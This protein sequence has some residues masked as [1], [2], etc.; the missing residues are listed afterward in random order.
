M[1]ISEINYEKW[2]KVL[3]RI[4]VI[5]ASVIFFVE[6]VDNLVLYITRSQGYGPDTI[7]E[8]L[9]RYLVITTAINLISI[10]IGQWLIKKHPDDIMLQKHALLITIGI[11]CVNATFSHYQFAIVY[12]IF[13]VPIIVSC[14]YEDIKL[15]MGVSVASSIG[16]VPGVVAR[17]I[18]PVYKKD[19]AAEAVIAYALILFFGIF[20]TT[21]IKLL[22]GRRDELNAALV[23]A[24]KA[25][26]IDVIDKK[27]LELQQEKERFKKLS[28]ETFIAIA[29]A[30]D[31]NDKYTAGHSER[32]ANYA[33]KIAIKMRLPRQ[34]IDEVYYA[35]LLHD[36][37]KIGIDNSVINKNGKLTPEEYDEIKRHPVMGYNI[38]KDIS[39]QGE[40]AMGARWHHE[41]PDGKGYPDGLTDIPLIAKIIS[42]AD[43]YDAMTSKRSYRDVM[44]QDK[45]REQIENGRGTQFDSN[46]ADV[47]LTMIDADKNYE[48]RQK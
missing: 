19:I 40:F 10:V 36:V 13:I 14:L 41:R 30:V 20:G 27:N 5:I 29:K 37:G 17:A 34:T 46:V 23:L 4:Q 42:V 7:V 32:V 31:V 11:I 28:E 33:K 18:D 25:K 44:S 1:Q 21:L 2:Q 15:T 8:K 39:V 47:M 48:M 9:I 26:Y 6:I 45:V 43:A 16:L 22:V 12:G 38:L 35:G 24:E 3:F